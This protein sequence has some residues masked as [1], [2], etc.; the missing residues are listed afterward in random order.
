MKEEGWDAK[1]GVTVLEGRWQEVV[2]TILEKGTLFD[3]IY[4]DTFAED[5]SAFRDFFS[6]QLVGLLV[7]GG[8]FSFFNGKS[9]LC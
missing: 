7:D 3:A 1:P 8:R 9:L 5:Y 4:F 2:P 6:D